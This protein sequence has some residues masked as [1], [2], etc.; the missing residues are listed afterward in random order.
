[1][2]EDRLQLFP[3]SIGFYHRAPV[4]PFMVLEAE[5]CNLVIL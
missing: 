1:M 5:F 3:D 2:C 4:P